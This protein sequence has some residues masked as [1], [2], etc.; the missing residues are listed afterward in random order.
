MTWIRICKDGLELNDGKGQLLRSVPKQGDAWPIG[1]L[2]AGEAVPGNLVIELERPMQVIKPPGKLGDFPKPHVVWA[3]SPNYSSRNGTPIRRIIN[4]QTTS[5]ATSALAWLRNP[6]S[7]VSAHYLVA[8]DG[9]IYQ[10]VEDSAK[11]WH[12]YQENGDAIGIEHEALN[13]DVLTAKQEQAT[14]ALQKYLMSE[15]EIDKAHVTGHRFTPHNHGLT[16]C[17]GR[18]FG[19]ASEQSLRTWVEKHL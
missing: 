11:A 19:E 13:G 9:T 8:K 14:I 6:A 5:P 3:P 15:Y 18:I 2:L 1:A 17:P 16:E 10:L 12:A 7:Q 4:H